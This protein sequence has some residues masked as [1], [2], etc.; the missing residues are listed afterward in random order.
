MIDIHEHNVSKEV[1]LDTKH[2]A[3]ALIELNIARKN[4]LIYPADHIQVKMSN[5]R[6]HEIL[7]KIFE[8]TPEITLGIAKDT[9]L[10]GSGYL[11]K[12]NPVY[13]E[14]ATALSEH[15]IAGITFYQG[16]DKEELFFFLNLISRTR[17]NLQSMGGIEK[18]IE[19]K[20]FLHIKI[21][22][23]DYSKFHLTEEAEIIKEK[24]D[25]KNEAGIW[26]DFVAHLLTDT[27]TESEDGL[28]L[29]DLKQINPA[30]LAYF[31]NEYKI[32]TNAALQS[33][34]NI[35][36]RHLHEADMKQ[37][38]D[39][40]NSPIFEKLNTLMQQLKPELKKQ[41]LATTFKHCSS[42]KNANQRE[43]FLNHLS[44]DLVIEMLIEANKRGEEISSSLMALVQK[45][46]QTKDDTD[47]RLT[48]KTPDPLPSERA[49]EERSE[50]LQNL[51]KQEEYE[52]YVISEY[53]NLIK[54]LT[55]EPRQGLFKD[56]HGFSIDEYLET[57]EDTCIDAR[58][59]RILITFM[60]EEDIQDDEYR[61]FAKKLVRTFPSLIEMGEFTF[62]LE[63]FATLARHSTEKPR[64][65]LRSAAQEALEGFKDSQ[66]VSKAVTCFNKVSHEEN[67]DAH[68]FIISLGPV[69]IPYLLQVYAS[70]EF[71][72]E[73]DIIFKILQGFGHATVDH[74]KT[75]LNS[76]KVGSVQNILFLLRTMGNK[77]LTPYLMP[78]CKHWDQNIRIE[79]LI[80]LLTFKDPWGIRQLR[81]AIRSNNP[82]E[83]NHAILQAG[84]YRIRDVAMDLV[85][86][87]KRF[88]LFE[89]YYIKNEKIIKALGQIGDPCALPA[90]EKLARSFFTIHPKSHLKMK[91]VL[92]ESLYHYPPHTLTTLLAIGKKSNDE[93]IRAACTKLMARQ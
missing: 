5:E 67:K 89:E 77:E 24:A 47:T 32:D 27:L 82:D 3:Q 9:L 1:P 2:L 30:Q 61:E 35:I 12:K 72:D 76:S 49:A 92:F 57:L 48:K 69:V 13:K 31:I 88:I 10:V 38:M 44:Q 64:Q 86:L 83:Y 14:F 11:D 4:V 80:T 39:R 33:Y 87:I 28:S 93:R 15:G 75:M 55:N 53:E 91:A 42:A 41:F 51:F 22:L 62:L 26:H 65:A 84:K 18:A 16:I 7:I 73:G 50:E 68:D 63:L 56:R 17:E 79:A 90:L 78:L 29:R 70:Q 20:G 54:Y 85:S 19:D 58:F 21:Q 81:N 8:L 45:L 34:E 60:E 36:T 74:A 40:R 43:A 6:A 25:I 66:I 37:R 59:A 71:I 52:K 46:S 23:L